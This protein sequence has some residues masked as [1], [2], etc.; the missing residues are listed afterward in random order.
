[1]GSNPSLLEGVLRVQGN[2][3]AIKRILMGLP[4]MVAVLSLVQV[5]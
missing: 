1:M 5:G 3:A 4:V 2:G